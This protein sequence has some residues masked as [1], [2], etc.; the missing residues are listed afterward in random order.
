[1][2]AVQSP[3]SVRQ[4]VPSHALTDIRSIG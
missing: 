4:K 2:Q 1:M 3:T